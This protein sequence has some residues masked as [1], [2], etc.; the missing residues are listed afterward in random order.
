MT[1]SA[2]LKATAL[3]ATAIA[4]TAGADVQAEAAT[5][6]TG[7]GGH[8]ITRGPLVTWQN[9]KTGRYLTVHNGGTANGDEVTTNPTDGQQQQ[10]WFMN[11]TGT[12]NASG[13]LQYHVKNENSSKCMAVLS[14]GGDIDQ[15]SCA[16]HTVWAEISVFK[17]GVRQGWLLDASSALAGFPR[18]ICENTTTHSVFLVSTNSPLAPGTNCLWH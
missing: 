7:P 17:N 9:K 5:T 1:T 8:R 3:L 11:S 6:A 12:S 16:N 15:W 18:V 13:H 10:H 14:S 4:V 2:K